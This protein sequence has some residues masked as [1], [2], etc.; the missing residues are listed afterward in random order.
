MLRDHREQDLIRDFGPA[1]AP[2]RPYHA[3]SPFPDGADVD[4]KALGQTVGRLSADPGLNGRDL[5]IIQVPLAIN[6]HFN[7]SRS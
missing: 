6:T 4:R 7:L 2:A 5:T 1:V 3:A